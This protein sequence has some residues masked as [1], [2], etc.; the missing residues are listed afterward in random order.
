MKNIIERDKKRRKMVKFYE[1]K[2][3][4]IK[5]QIKKNYNLGL[6]LVSL[7]LKLRKL[8]KN[9][10]KVRIQNRCVITGRSRSVYKSFK[11]SRLQLKELCSKGLIPGVNRS[12]W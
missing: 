5:L 3:L 1:K 12:S 6:D 2:R 9:S 7:Y 8:P 10:C 4:L 11:I